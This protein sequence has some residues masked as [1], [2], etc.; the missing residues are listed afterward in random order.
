[1]SKD[2]IHSHEFS[3]LIEKERKFVEQE[4]DKKYISTEYTGGIKIDGVG[5]DAEIVTNERGGKQS[6]SPMALHLVDP[7]FL[8]DWVG[9]LNFNEYDL[10]NVPT[11]ILQI[12]VFMET[13]DKTNIFR[14]ITTLEKDLTK[15][16]TRIA[17][18]LQVGADRYE[19]NNWRLI[20]QES[21]I[22]HALIHL[23]A[24]LM[25]DTQDDHLDH[26][27]CRLMMAY[28]TE[29]S[30]GFDYNRYVPT[31]GT[32]VETATSHPNFKSIV[33]VGSGETKGLCCYKYGCDY[34]EER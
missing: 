20:P 23:V 31:V 19:P 26:A 30:E 17:K 6:K 1:M 14:A 22:N 4:L 2:M 16:L 29:K 11:A 5:R 18:V 7:Q 10:N 12:A 21:H 8:K 13:L 9:F 25:G 27:L 34:K 24:H 3:D 15:A 28:A 32:I 33:R